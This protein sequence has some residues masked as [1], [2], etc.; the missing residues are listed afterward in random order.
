MLSIVLGAVEGAKA[1]LN[2]IKNDNA[3]IFF[4]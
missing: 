2:M 1:Y 4:F 3:M